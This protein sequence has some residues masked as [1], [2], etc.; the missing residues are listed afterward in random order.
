MGRRAE[1]LGQRRL[2]RHELG[3]A[4]EGEHPRVLVPPF[5]GHVLL[6]LAHELDEAQAPLGLGDGLVVDGCL[7]RGSGNADGARIVGLVRDVLL[8]VHDGDCAPTDQEGV[9]VNRNVG[10]CRDV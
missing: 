5:G 3:G 9:E 1:R 6:D 7:A 8:V 2:E 4:G 10:C